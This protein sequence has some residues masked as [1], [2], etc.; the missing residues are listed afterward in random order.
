MSRCE[1]PSYTAA[2]SRRGEGPA[3]VVRRVHAD[4]PPALLALARIQTSSLSPEVSRPPKTIRRSFSASYAPADASRADGA[5]P[6]EHA[7]DHRWPVVP[8]A[9]PKWTSYVSASPSASDDAHDS[10][11]FV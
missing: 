9:V 5:V 4:G 10:V 3:D 11:G 7:V 2:A 1:G 6:V 8:K